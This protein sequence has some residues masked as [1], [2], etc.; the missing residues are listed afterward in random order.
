MILSLGGYMEEE[1]SQVW[2]IVMQLTLEPRK[3]YCGNYVITYL[4]EIVDGDY[5][6]IT[7]F[8]EK[9]K[10]YPSAEAANAVMNT[11]YF[12]KWHPDGK[13]F[14]MLISE[15]RTVKN[16]HYLDQNSILHQ[17]IQA[18]VDE[19]YAEKQIAHQKYLETLKRISS[20]EETP[21]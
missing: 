15:T 6:Q 10:H 18:L 14:A 4:R 8:L 3:F 11:E 20:T 19:T 7:T 16:L 1:I 2:V 21:D 9:A 5:T 17:K 13:P 12:K